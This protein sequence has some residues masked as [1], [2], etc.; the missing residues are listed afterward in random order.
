L[1][2]PEKNTEI[3]NLKWEKNQQM[4]NNTGQWTKVKG[5]NII[6]LSGMFDIIGNIAVGWTQVL[7]L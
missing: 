6:Q 4:Q 3:W 1:L 2:C 7:G 5:L